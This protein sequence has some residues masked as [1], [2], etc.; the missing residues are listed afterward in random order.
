MLLLDQISVLM[1]RTT[2]IICVLWEHRENWTAG[3]AESCSKYRKAI[4]SKPIYLQNYFK[5][6]DPNNLNLVISNSLLSL[7]FAFQ[8]FTLGYF[9]LLLF[10]TIYY[11]PTKFEIVGFIVCSVSF[12]TLYWSSPEELQSSGLITTRVWLILFSTLTKWNDDSTS[13]KP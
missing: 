4:R 1:N 9:E 10:Q 2:M 12:V 5:E 11:F 3:K 13:L 8:S 7:G 6:L